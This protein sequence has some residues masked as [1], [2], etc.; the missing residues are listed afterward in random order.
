MRS[1]PTTTSCGPPSG[2]TAGRRTTCSSGG[3]D[4]LTASGGREL[5]EGDVAL[6]GDDTIHAVP[7]PRCSYTGAIHVYGG[8]LPGRTDRTEWDGDREVPVDFDVAR[9]RFEEAN[10]AL[11]S[12]R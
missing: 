6:L 11:A 3:P 9:R 7:N 2:S 8:D 10:A 1:P 4:R 5:R 12:A